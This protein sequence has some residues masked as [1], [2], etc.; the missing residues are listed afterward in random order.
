MTDDEH[1]D[2]SDL[3]RFLRD[4]VPAPGPGYWD[5]IDERLAAI[6]SNT[7]GAETDADT[8][9]ET[10]AGLG[11]VPDAGAP[12]SIDPDG[13]ES[14]ETT[15]TGAEV[16]RLTDMTTRPAHRFRSAP[17]LVG[18]AAALVVLLGLGVALTRGDNAQEVATD[19]GNPDTETTELDA[20]Q[21]DDSD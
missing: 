6:G 7:A 2:P 4:E 12:G 8:D 16:I 19:D 18:A 15:D 5:A 13:D 21:T 1:T 11:S 10:D 17:M 20:D 3:G 9:A 14:P